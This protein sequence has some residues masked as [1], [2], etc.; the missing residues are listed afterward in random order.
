VV[1]CF[2]SK[3]AEQIG[4]GYSVLPSERSIELDLKVIESELK[5]KTLLVYWHLLSSPSAPISVRGLQRSLNFSS[6]SVAVYHLD[7]LHDLGLVKKD[8]L[9][10]YCL[11]EEVKVG[12]LSFFFRVGRFLLPRYLFY[13]IFFTTMFIL[14]IGIYP[15]TGSVDNIIALILGGVASAVLWY[16]TMRIWLQK[17]F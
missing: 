3:K 15:Q 16:E 4:F 17:P 6:P 5:G 10:Q 8:A 7:K 12:L 1:V 11:T 13:A 14:Y 9:G 2:Y